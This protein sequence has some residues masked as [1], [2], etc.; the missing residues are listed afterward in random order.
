MS[1]AARS[2]F[3]DTTMSEQAQTK[4][5][6]QGG[7]FERLQKAK[8]TIERQGVLTSRD[9]KKILKSRA[10]KLSIGEEKK[11]E[12]TAYREVLEFILGGERYALEIGYIRE[13]YPMKEYTVLPCTPPFITGIINVHGQVL[14]IMD[15]KKF[16]DLP[17]KGLTD[18][19]KAIIVRKDDIELGILADEV[20]GFRN[21]GELELQPGFPI[22]K[23][24]RADFL[25]GMTSEGLIVIDVSRLLSD[26]R[27]MVHEE[28]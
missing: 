14:T 20:L 13:I 11:G 16:F 10:K 25:K 26:K 19:N 24:L 3:G 22:L 8:K 21:I 27:I 18:L 2:S 17:E 1:E 5:P 12:K 28:V 15:M 23:D 9:K 6:T 4:S 7:V